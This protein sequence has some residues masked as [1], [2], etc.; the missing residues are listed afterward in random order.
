M[1][2]VRLSVILVVLALA[3]TAPSPEASA[4]GG[5]GGAGEVRVAGT[6]GKGA[7]SKLRL[8]ARDGGIRVQFEVDHSRAGGAWRVVLVQ[9]RRVVWRGRA[10]TRGVGDSFEIQRRLRD[11]PGADQV[12]ARASGPG[13]LTCAASATLPG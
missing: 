11:L 4:R 8:R 10:R 1:P 13:G 12:T 5:G 9:D 7:T 3:L 2:L 6:C